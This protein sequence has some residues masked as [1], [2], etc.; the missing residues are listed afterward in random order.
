M[1][2]W[3]RL[4][5]IPMYVKVCGAVAFHDLSRAPLSIV[6]CSSTVP[7]QKPVWNICLCFSHYIGIII[8]ETIFSYSWAI[9]SAIRLHLKIFRRLHIYYSVAKPSTAC[10][11]LK[12]GRCIWV[13][14]LYTVLFRNVPKRVVGC[15]GGNKSS[16]LRQTAP[17]LHYF[18]LK[19]FRR[20]YRCLPKAVYKNTPSTT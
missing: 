2:M 4:T 19:P 1:I 11:N 15:I 13:T 9:Y 12:V 14:L 10:L 20:W 18:H 5:H 6:S 16:N 3:F 7:M 8:P 17:V